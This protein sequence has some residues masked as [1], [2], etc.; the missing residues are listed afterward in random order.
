[1]EEGALLVLAV[2]FFLFLPITDR[3]TTRMKLVMVCALLGLFVVSVT[4]THVS[5]VQLARVVSSR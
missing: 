4:Q 5:R 3:K 1:M 2:L